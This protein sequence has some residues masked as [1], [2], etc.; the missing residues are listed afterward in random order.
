MIIDPSQPSRKS[1]LPPEVRTFVGAFVVRQRRV[2]LLGAAGWAAAFALAWL[3]VDCVLD[4]VLHLS[5]GLRWALLAANVIGILVL[6]A[7]PLARM[8]RRR[9][10][11]LAAAAQIESRGGHFGQRLQTITSQMLADPAYRGS[12]QLLDSILDDLRQDLSR[13]NAAALAPVRAAAWS[14]AAA[15][16]VVV[17]FAALAA[18][19]WLQM[20]RLLARALEPWAPRP[21]VTTTTLSV[22]PGNAQIRQG[23]ELIISVTATHLGDEPP[24][25]WVSND[26]SRTWQQQAMAAASAQHFDLS[27]G[28]VQSDLQ[29]F[30]EGGDARSDR[31]TVRVLR[32]PVVRQF[33]VHYEYPA[34]TG[35]PPLSVTNTDGL[36]E[37][38][39]GSTA[40][41]EAVCTEAL[42]DARLIAGGQQIQMLPASQPNVRKCA[43]PIEHDQKLELQLLGDNQVAGSGPSTMAIR[44]IPDLPPV[45]KFIEPTGD[46]RLGERDSLPVTYLAT[47]DYGVTSV[48]L[49]VQVNLSSAQEISMP[50]GGEPRYRRGTF[51]LDLSTLHV[52]A[53]DLVRLS[54]TA[55]DNGGNTQLGDE[56]RIILISQRGIDPGTRMGLTEVQRAALLADA[57]AKNVEAAAKALQDAR[58]KAGGDVHDPAALSSTREN[59]TSAANE[60]ALLRQAILAT[61]A[62]SDSPALSTALARWADGAQVIIGAVDRASARLD[63]P[64]QSALPER[65]GPVAKRARQLQQDLNTLAQGQLAATVRSERLDSAAQQPAQK[66]AQETFRKV[67]NRLD[68]QLNADAA[69]LGLDPAQPDFSDRLAELNDRAAD[70]IAKQHPIDYARVADS[71]AKRLQQGNPPDSDMDARLSVAAEAESLR[72]DADMVR[73]RDLRLAAQAAPAMVAGPAAASRDQFS[74]ALAAMQRDEALQRIDAHPVDPAQAQRIDAEANAARAKMAAWAGSGQSSDPIVTAG[75]RKAMDLALKSNEQMARHD[76][77]AAAQTDQALAQTAATRPSSQV[78]QAM[79]SAQTIDQIRREQDRLAAQTATAGADQNQQLAQR[80]QAIAQAVAQQDTGANQQSRTGGIAAIQSAMARL[81]A[82]PDQLAQAKTAA[83]AH[84]QALQQAQAAAKKLSAATQPADQEAAAATSQEAKNNQVQADNRQADAAKAVNPDLA[85]AISQ[86]LTKSSPPADDAA[87]TVDRQ[88]TPALRQLRQAMDASDAAGTDGAISTATAAVSAAQQQLREALNQSINR[89]PLAAASFFAQAAAQELAA[90]NPD[91][92]AVGLNQSNA[93]VALG[94]AWQRAAH[95]AAMGRLAQVP[96]LANLLS[97]VDPNLIDL[98][99]TESGTVWSVDPL[100]AMRD[101][102]QLQTRSVGSLSAS[103]NETD[104]AGYEESLKAYFEALNR[105]GQRAGGQ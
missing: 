41:L 57:L 43:I 99:G 30:V 88:L 7:P 48:G 54:L 26:D 15:A 64:A 22:D 11:W 65:L 72:S 97:P 40:T 62:H 70:L 104:P 6:L 73:A 55:D 59:L 102:G 45:V 12:E 51:V 92:D 82:M 61:I 52:K 89:D 84:R 93:S 75:D 13:G 3:V 38:P 14:W 37:A 32:Q 67:A 87:A 81:S 49:R 71:W 91:R 58:A 9:I 95:G 90:S 35:K 46:L 77:A 44:A 19:P 39:V 105:T 83:A 34:Y 17:I 16:G 86:A 33:R 63:T 76:Y 100:P 2:A 69:K 25:L 94:K 74:P 24:V 96:S 78:S 85:R 79:A 8:L 98:S 47:D 27:L 31:F 21:P 60:A 36:I 42:A 10:D 5:Q 56:E 66:D 20:P 28:A 53:G 68:Q 103:L 50:L 1:T 101:W 23:K 18:L 4:R 80:Q 29:Y